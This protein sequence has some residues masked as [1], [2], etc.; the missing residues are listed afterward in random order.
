[1][2]SVPDGRL[3]W[4]QDDVPV[5]FLAVSPDG[6]Y[7]ATAGFTQPADDPAPDGF[8]EKSSVT[9]RDLRTG[10]Q[11]AVR[12]TDN[13]KPAAIAFSPDSRSLAVGFFE[14]KADVL[15]G[16]T[17]ARQ[18]TMPQPATAVAFAPDGQQLLAASFDGTVTA[19]ENA[20]WSAAGSFRTSA[21]GHAHL[22]YSTGGQFLLISDA[23][24]TSL[25]DADRHRLIAEPLS[26]QGDG[27]N[28]ALFL[29]PVPETDVV[30]LASQT[31]L[32][33]LDMNPAHWR[34]QAC[35]LAVRRLTRD[36]WRRFLPD[37]PYRPACGTVPPVPAPPT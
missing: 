29:A 31:A 15:D 10:R 30:Y 3:L 11:V 23:R 32:A 7:V 1:M 26:L 22:A 6:R 34:Q 19:Y 28:D 12:G 4:S 27:T 13:R 16:R 36:E 18:A 21:D 25:W 14:D 35:S 2:W 9:L 37:L 8:A 5:S 33:R 17:L 24:A 20:D